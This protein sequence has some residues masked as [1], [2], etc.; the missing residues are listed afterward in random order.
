METIWDTRTNRYRA[1]P[2]NEHWQRGNGPFKNAA[3]RLPSNIRK[4]LFLA[5]L[6]EK[7]VLLSAWLVKK[8]LHMDKQRARIKA[9]LAGVLDGD[10]RCDDLTLQLYSS[11]ASLYQ[12]QPLAVVQP[13][14]V[15][16]V[17][18]TVRY[19]AENQHPIHPRGA[20]TGV[21][22][23]C[24]GEGIVI[25]FSVA[26]RRI[27]AWRNGQ[28]TV[29]P[30][31]VLAGLN[32][33]LHTEGHVFGPDPAT[34]SVTTIG[35]VL[36]TNASGSHWARYGSPR[37]KIA[38]LQIVLPNGSI[39]E[40]PSRSNPAF[41]SLVDP[42]AKRLETE[43]GRILERRR[44]TLESDPVRSRVN[45]VGYCLRDLR[46]DPGRLDLTRLICG[47]EGTL[48]IITEATLKTDPKP[49]QR[50]ICILFF[51]KIEQAGQA[52][53][54]IDTMSPSACDLMDRRLL[55]IA[56]ET[57]EAYHRA[58][59]ADTEAI[60]L[61]EFDAESPLELREKLENVAN[62]IHR[63]KKL[64]FDY[65]TTMIA[66]ERNRFWRLARRVVPILYRLKG[67]RRALPFVEDLAI[68]PERLPEFLSRIHEVL[69]RYEVTAS[70]FCHTPQGHVDIRPFLDL[71]NPDHQRLMPRLARELFELTLRF[72]GTI[73][74]ANG[75]G[76]SRTWFLRSQLG[77]RYDVY[78]EVK[79]LFDPKFA[80]NPGKIINFPVSELTDRLRKVGVDASLFPSPPLKAEKSKSE[81][82]SG[83]SSRDRKPKSLPIIEPQLS[84]SLEEMGHA[85]RACNGC[86][87]CRTQGALERMCPVF[88]LNPVE[89][90]S[91]RAKANLLRN[92]LNGQTP[93]DTLSDDQLRSIADLCV[94][95]HQ[96]R[97]E[98]PVG[99][100]IPKIVCES[101][102]QYVATTGLKFSQWIFSRLD[103]AYGLG[104]AFPTITNWAL[105][106]R[107]FRWA[108]DRFL[109]IAQGRKLPR[110]SRRTFLNWASRRQPSRTARGE[111]RKVVY[112]VDAYAN[113]NDVEI[114]RAVVNVLE[115][116]GV[117][118]FVP[119]KQNLSGMSLISDGLV[120]RAKRIAKQNVEILADAVRQG[121]RVV[122]SEPSANLALTHEYL[123]LIDEVDAKLVAENCSDVNSYLWEL[124]RQG[125]L[126]LDFKPLNVTVGYHTPCHVRAVYPEAPVLKLLKL[127]PGLTLQSIDQGCSGMAGMYGL[128]R[129]NYR[130]SLRAGLG[131]IS[132]LRNPDMVLG[133]TDCS[134]CKMQMEHGTP[135]PTV[136]P[137]KLMALAYNLMPE[138]ADLFR[139]KSGSKVLS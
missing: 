62:R 52:A 71:T 83:K 11:D 1:I 114:G 79:R 109:G 89:E 21:T 44:S 12:I 101:K 120:S 17:A 3:S 48:G 7:L 77:P 128:K 8:S 67:N 54:E 15:N 75:D 115:H 132:S 80:F 70:I 38:H 88:R 86:G 31:V 63:R 125:M 33:R 74:A 25:D 91:P 100:D 95:C 35:S 121:Y 92:V 39:V 118:V 18:T 14:N 9:D 26:M 78:R 137:I 57:D 6:S 29:Q 27:S 64:A 110:F 76:L 28:V 81:N 61:V 107:T 123:N 106:S 130:K 19:A 13:R 50:G 129:E 139:R 104:G 94:N 43:V 69:N 90:A 134:T 40:M 96:C 49:V 73:S 59:P 66:E 84:W 117:E 138:L 112:F 36:A 122:T 16:D 98:C 136:H 124:H 58:I 108:L 32:R 135:K 55:S 47:S 103:F 42:E 133:V 97:N 68:P 46:V 60:L 20:G 41:E 10:V 65:R 56:R 131:L 22:G 105:Q 116:N 111:R 82:D 34:R 102:A 126:E 72:D 5:A 2:G 93:A 87:R 24:L 51:D 23:G 30:G 53:I 37:D 85:V 113:W 127:V 45:G 4:F 99:V 119:L